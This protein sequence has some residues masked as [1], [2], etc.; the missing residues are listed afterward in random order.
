MCF[1]GQRLLDLTTEATSSEDQEKR[2]EIDARALRRTFILKL[3]TA[4]GGCC[5]RYPLDP[6]KLDECS[7]LSLCLRSRREWN[8]IRM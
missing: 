8:D 3:V 1:F 4:D 7:D 2:K 6:E 5:G